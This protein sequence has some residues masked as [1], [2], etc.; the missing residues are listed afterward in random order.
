M[1]R[2]NTEMAINIASRKTNHGNLNTLFLLHGR[3][4]PLRLPSSGRSLR[5]D[6]EGYKELE[7]ELTHYLFDNR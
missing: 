4:H 5:H 3:D 6:Q 7:L 1:N 2:A